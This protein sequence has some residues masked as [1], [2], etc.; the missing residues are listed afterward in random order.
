[1]I[2]MILTTGETNSEDFTIT[3]R[4]AAI[5]IRK[6]AKVPNKPGGTTIEFNVSINEQGAIHPEKRTKRM[7]ETNK[8]SNEDNEAVIQRQSSQQN[9]EAKH[10]SQKKCK[11]GTGQNYK[12]QRNAYIMKQHTGNTKRRKQHGKNTKRT[13]RQQ[14]SAK[15]KELFEHRERNAKQRKRNTDNQQQIIKLTKSVK[16]QNTNDNNEESTKRLDKSTKRLYTNTQ[17]GSITINKVHTTKIPYY[18]GDRRILFSS[19]Q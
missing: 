9:H 8:T 5:A 10:R 18:P 16:R 7:E 2:T 6:N 3:I 13:T 19:Q 1:M 15:R 12:E 17:K 11:A 4:E 14:I